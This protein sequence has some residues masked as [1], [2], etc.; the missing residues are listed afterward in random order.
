M[1]IALTT[2][3]VLVGACGG[4]PNPWPGAVDQAKAAQY[5]DA[6]AKDKVNYPG[7]F[8]DISW[9]RAVIVGVTEVTKKDSIALKIS[10][11]TAEGDPKSVTF[12]NATN[13]RDKI[14]IGDYVAYNGP[15]TTIN[16]VGDHFIVITASAI[17]LA[18]HPS[19]SPTASTGK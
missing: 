8:S 14:R 1:F 5:M 18:G 17:P 7:H 10:L 2:T 19:D 3:L 4:Q 6:H 16:E 12:L 15:L 11:L 9:T 13:Q